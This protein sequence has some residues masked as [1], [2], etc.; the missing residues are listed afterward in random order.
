MA[1][2]IIHSNSLFIKYFSVSAFKKLKIKTPLWLREALAEFMGTF[3]LLVIKKIH[4]FVRLFVSLFL[5]PLPLFL[6]SPFICLSGYYV[7]LSV[8]S[9]RVFFRPSMCPSLHPWMSVHSPVWLSMCQSIR[10]SMCQSVSQSVRQSINQL[11]YLT[12]GQCSKGQ[13]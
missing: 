5:L 4:F 3:I 1:W 7:R 9:F 12:K 6:R 11:C 2:L 8:L 13:L 10:L